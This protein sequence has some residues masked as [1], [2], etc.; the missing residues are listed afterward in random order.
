MSKWCMR[1][2]LP[3]WTPFITID[4]MGVFASEIESGTDKLARYLVTT[5]EHLLACVLF[6]ATIPGSRQS[7]HRTEQ[8]KESTFAELKYLKR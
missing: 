5:P 6:I 1:V 8:A 3:V 2:E 7:T 4:N